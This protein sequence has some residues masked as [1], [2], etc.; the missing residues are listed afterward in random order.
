MVKLNLPH[1]IAALVRRD[2]RGDDSSG[3]ACRT[4]ECYF[5]WYVDVRDV[6]VFTEEWKVQH[7]DQ[8][9]RYESL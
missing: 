2:T 7:C 1:Q 5:A 8:L 9:V 3:D 4:P 6:F